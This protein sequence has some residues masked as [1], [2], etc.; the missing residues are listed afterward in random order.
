MANSPDTIPFGQENQFDK[1]WSSAP[2]TVPFGNQ[3]NTPINSQTQQPQKSFLQKAGD[4]V[5]G[6][7]DF[8]GVN[9]L[10]KGLANVA[11]DKLAPTGLLGPEAK[12]LV[13][14]VHN[15]NATPEQYKAYADI[16]GATPTK[17]QV[18]GSAIQTA[19]NIGSAGI[20]TE[21][22]SAGARIASL[23]LQS[24]GAGAAQGFGQGLEQQKSIGQ[25]AGQGALTGAVTGV[26]GAGIQGVGE[27][28]KLLTSQG[29]QE[30]IVNKTL[31]IPTKV[32][33]KGKSPAQTILNDVGISSKKGI[34]NT[35]NQAIS[36]NGQKISELLQGNKTPI[37]TTKILDTIKSKLNDVYGLVLSPEEIDKAVNKLPLNEITKS[38]QVS[39]DTLNK[40]RQ[41]IDN[42][43]LGNSKWLGTSTA[44]SITGLKTA[45]NVMRNIVQGTVPETQ[46]LFSKMA[47]YITTRNAV[48]SSLA[49]PHLMTQMLEM[50][51]SGMA[52]LVGGGGVN[53]KAVAEATASYAL[54]K[55][56]LSTPTQLGI[57]QGLKL[58][59]KVVASGAAQ[60]VGKIANIGAQNIAKK[61]I[62]Q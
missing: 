57:A 17:G 11:Y 27:L 56:F 50:L 38:P 58:G 36:D 48:S 41:V 37:D 18:V 46:P 24:A 3:Q 30:S 14:T 51:G 34:L 45:A 52:G 43:Y 47:D 6:V 29:V 25:S 15:G 19:A 35:S 13:D 9:S 53:P 7:G 55:A 60:G 62:G 33:Q 28:A 21:A 2:D 39:V 22:A 23:G 26:V 10:G 40:V 49:K 61:I 42:Q 16:Y 20:G 32:V 4:A 1:S 31:G 5:S 54:L 8:L 59:G 12:Q 44:E